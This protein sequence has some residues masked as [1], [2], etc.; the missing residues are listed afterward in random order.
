M[1]AFAPIIESIATILWPIIVIIILLSF[2][3]NIQS[4]IKS[5]ENRKFTVK[6]G[7]ME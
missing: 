3:K 1:E 7:E 2:R 6:I 5:G 4:L